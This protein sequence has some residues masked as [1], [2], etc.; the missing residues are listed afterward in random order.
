MTI[1]GG[2]DGTAVLLEGVNQ[3]ILEGEDLP[4]V[5]F[6]FSAAFGGADFDPVGRPVVDAREALELNESL[7]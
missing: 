1:S 5:L 3:D 2:E 6:E 7:Q 4:V